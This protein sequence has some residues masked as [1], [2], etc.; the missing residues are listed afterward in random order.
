LIEQ[1]IDLDS[2]CQ[3]TRR[4]SEAAFKQE[5]AWVSHLSLAAVL[6]PTPKPNACANYARCVNQVIQELNYV[7][8]WV[9]IPLVHPV[10]EDSCYDTYTTADDD[11]D[12]SG[13]SNSSS[14]GDN[15]K[16]QNEDADAMQVCSKYT[17]NMLYV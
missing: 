15:S 11:D 1:W 8:A 16:Q 4:A 9:R 5:L 17:H 7:Q 10:E 14:S 3:E 2:T 13:S 6:L 12:N